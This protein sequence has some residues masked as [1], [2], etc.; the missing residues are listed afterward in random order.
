MAISAPGLVSVSVTT[1][2]GT[3][4]DLND[5]GLIVG[6]T[7]DV[8]S[9]PTRQ[10]ANGEMPGVM[11]AVRL[12]SLPTGGVSSVTVEGLV[13]ATSL[14]NLTSQIRNLKGWCASAV[15]LKTFHDANTY[16]AVSA[17]RSTVSVN[18]P[19]KGPLYTA[20][21][22]IEFEAADPFWY[23]TSQTT[24]TFTG[25]ATATALGSTDSY[26]VVRLTGAFT[27]PTITVKNSSGST[28]ATMVFTIVLANAAHYLEIDCNPVTGRTVVKHTG[29]LSAAEDTLTSGDFFGFLIANADRLTPTWG[30]IEASVTAGSISTATA[31]YRKRYE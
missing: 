26:P 27:N 3:Y 25:G 24:V 21:A 4:K 30:T 7:P 15:A 5:F 23:D 17:V 8:F 18:Y 31:I 14:A 2:T 11:R 1:V 22:S 19:V 10:W 16:L 28:V 9:G 13:V 12:N 6:A 29:S 20:S